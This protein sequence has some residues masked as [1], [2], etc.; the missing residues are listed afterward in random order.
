MHRCQSKQSYLIRISCFCN[1]NTNY[2][3][4]RNYLSGNYN[5]H[6]RLRSPILQTTWCRHYL[7]SDISLF[8]HFTNPTHFSNQCVYLG[9]SIF[10]LRAHSSYQFNDSYF[11]G[12]LSIGKHEKH[13]CFLIEN[14]RLTHDTISIGTTK[15]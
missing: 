6:C 1:C 5:N 4:P 10:L 9:S 13:S 2:K 11:P 7:S 14:L 3:H 8:K 15:P 12:D